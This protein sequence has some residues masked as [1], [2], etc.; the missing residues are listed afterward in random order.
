MIRISRLPCLDMWPHIREHNFLELRHVRT[1][2]H[3]TKN[4][5]MW[6]SSMSRHQPTQVRTQLSITLPCSDIMP[7]ENTIFCLD[8][9][10]TSIL[11]VRTSAYVIVFFEGILQLFNYKPKYKNCQCPKKQKT[12]FGHQMNQLK[13]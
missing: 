4:T 1:P 6:K 12:C 13:T 10:R 2:T 8:H 7:E 5:T 9:V 11:H 3:M